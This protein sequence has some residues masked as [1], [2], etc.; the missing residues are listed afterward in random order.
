MSLVSSCELTHATNYKID[1]KIG[2]VTGLDPK[3][4]ALLLASLDK[5]LQNGGIS[6]D[7]STK[8]KML[9]AATVGGLPSGELVSGALKERGYQLV[10]PTEHENLFVL[11]HEGGPLY[12][13][14][15]SLIP[16]GYYNQWLQRVTAEV[17]GD[18]KKSNLPLNGLQETGLVTAESAA[19]AILNA[20]CRSKSTRVSKGSVW[21]VMRGIYQPDESKSVALV[22]F[23]DLLETRDAQ[24]QAIHSWKEERVARLPDSAARLNSYLLKGGLRSLNAADV[25]V[26]L[27]S[28]DPV[29]SLLLLM[30]YDP[31]V[32]TATNDDPAI[33]A[34]KMR[35][36]EIEAV[37][38][39]ALWFSDLNEGYGIGRVKR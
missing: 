32:L 38:R 29:S 12:F 10:L 34:K 26:A 37:L 7:A 8:L 24:K 39:Q 25:Q 15:G 9:E 18:K 11:S 30:G 4:L 21:T 1:R 14:S 19:V 35:T 5:I 27:K 2:E 22:V 3:Q 13:Q 36:R 33:L 17:V 28:N 16:G 23:G 31:E 6:L 20:Y